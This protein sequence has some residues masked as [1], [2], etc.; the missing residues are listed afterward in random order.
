MISLFPGL[1][2]LLAAGCQQ[3]EQSKPA[4]HTGIGEETA[5]EEDTGSEAR[6]LHLSPGEFAVDVGAR[7]PLRAVLEG[8]DGSRVDVTVDWMSTDPAVV[9]VAAG[10]CQ[11]HAT[12]EAVIIAQYDGLEAQAH[13]QVQQSGELRVQVIDAATG[14]PIPNARLLDP[15]EQQVVDSEGRGVLQVGDEPVWITA[16]GPMGSNYI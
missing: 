9:G 12:G 11:A 8:E 13:V 6:S 2:A 3:P 10:E 1:I 14:A 16:Y 15:D 5:I 7:W 4:D